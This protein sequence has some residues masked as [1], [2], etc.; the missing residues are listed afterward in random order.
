MKKIGVLLA[1]VL[2]LSGCGEQEYFKQIYLEDMKTY[3]EEG[4]SGFILVVNEND[5]DFQEYVKNVAESE[6]VEIGMYNVYE[7]EKG[8]QDNRPVVPFD[9]FDTF[10]EL[11]YVE[12]NEE[13]GSLEVTAYEDMRLTEETKHFVDLHK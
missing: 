1:L 10:N 3:M 12:N 8:A 7:S 9:G 5:Q 11:Y 13:K 2:L 6:E 4:E